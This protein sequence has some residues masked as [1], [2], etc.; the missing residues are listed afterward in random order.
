MEIYKEKV[1]HTMDD[2]ALISIISKYT[3]VYTY[4]LNKIPPAIW[5]RLL[6]IL[7]QAGDDTRNKLE[8]ELR[9]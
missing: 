3:A 2:K 9:S 8:M 1:L 7:E 5:D 4:E 6:P